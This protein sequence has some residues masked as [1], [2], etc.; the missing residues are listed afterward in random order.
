MSASEI[1]F[2]TNILIYFASEE[3]AKADRS[4]ALLRAG[5]IVSVQVLNEFIAATRRKSTLPW[6]NIRTVLTAVRSTCTVVPLTV[7]THVRGL[8]LAERYGFSVYD[9]MIVAAAAMAGCK[10]L[11]SEDM[12]D[13]LVIDGLAIRNPYA[14]GQ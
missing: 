10:V 11:Y 9:A 12:H 5:G 1:F 13:G 6:E 4:D 14:A 2:D 3:T 7:E 8:A